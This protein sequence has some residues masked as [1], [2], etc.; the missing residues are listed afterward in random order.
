MQKHVFFDLDHTL[1]PSRARM[2]PEHEPIFATLCD[3]ADVIIVTGGAEDQIRKQI[4][5]EPTGRFFMLSQQGNFAVHKDGRELW[6]E[7]M[8]A[9]QESVVKPF[10]RMLTDEF[11]SSEG[12]SLEDE[13]DIFEN[14]GSQFAS[15][16]IGFHQPNEKKYAADPDQSKR[17]ALLAAHKDEV[18]KL[19]E[20]G[21]EVMPAGTTTFDFILSGKHKGYNISR[22]LEAEGWITEDCIYLG[23]AL[24]PGGNDETVVGVIPTRPVTDPNQTFIFINEMLS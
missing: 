2:L 20:A 16:V 5:F 23:D 18:A 24:F 14:R 6:H 8:S 1:T 22:L 4:P 21:V 12:I 17:R 13:N 15:S 9:E 19:R 3:R 11:L 10:A 7:T